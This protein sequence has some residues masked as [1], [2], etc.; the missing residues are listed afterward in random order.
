[1]KKLV[2]IILS[3]L[4][5]FTII[6][7]ASV[8]VSAAGN[9]DWRWPVPSS[10]SLSS[11]Y[12]DGRNHCALD[13]VGA[14]GCAIYA[15]YPGTVVYTVRN[16]CAHNYGTYCGCGGGLGNAVYI[17]H[18]YQ[19][20]SYI[21]RYGHLT[22]VNVSNG[23]SVS[24]NTV[25][26]T[27]G[28]TGDSSGFHLDLRICR[29]STAGEATTAN[30]IDPFK[31]QFLEMPSGFNANGATT[32]CCYTYVNEVKS[33][34]ATPSDTTAPTI[35]NVKVSNVTSTGYT[36]TCNVSDNVG[37]TRVAF[38]TWTAYA[39]QDDLKWKDGTINGN[40]ATFNVKTSDHNNE[41]GIY[42]THIYAYD[43]AGKSTSVATWCNVPVDDIICCDDSKSYKNGYYTDDDEVLRLWGWAFSNKGKEVSFK[44]KIDD[45]NEIKIENVVRTDVKNA[46]SSIC[47]F[48]NVGYDVD[49]EL[50]KVESG[51]HTVVII[52]TST[53]GNS[54]VVSEHSFYVSH[55]A[56][57]ENNKRTVTFNNH[58]YEIYDQYLDYHKALEYCESKGGHLATISSAFENE[59]IYQSIKGYKDTYFLG[60][61]DEVTE[62][63]W[64]WCDGTNMTYSNWASTQPDNAGS[65]EHYLEMWS[66]S[67]L[68]NDARLKSADYYAEVS[69]FICE[70]EDYEEQGY[71]F[72]GNNKYVL[73]NS[74]LTWEEAKTFAEE[75]GGHLVTITSPHENGIVGCLIQVHGTCNNY[76]LGAKKVTETEFE[77]V[78]GEEWIY[79]NWGENEPNEPITSSY[80]QISAFDYEHATGFKEAYT[81]NDILPE[82]GSSDF[83]LL[84]NSGFIVE[85]ENVKK[86]LENCDISLEYATTDYTGKE[87]TPTITIKDGSTT[88]VKGTDYTVEYLNNTDVGTASVVVIGKGNYTGK[89]IK[90]F[91]IV[92]KNH[93]YSDWT[94]IEQA[95]CTEKGEKICACLICEEE[96]KEIIP[97]L[98]HTEVID[99]AVAPTCTK[100]GLTQGKHCSTCD[101]VLVKQE[102]VNKA[103]HTPS[104]DWVVTKPATTENSG[105]RVKHCTVCDEI[106][107]TEVIPKLDVVLPTNISDCEI[108]VKYSSTVY[109][110]SAKKPSV[111]VKD[112]STTL[113]NGTDYAVKYSNNL[114]AG[115]ATITIKGKGNYTGTVTK[116]FE[117]EK[118]SFDSWGLPPETKAV[119]YPANNLETRYT[120][121]MGDY[122]LIKDIDYTVSIVGEI[123]IGNIVKVIYT[124]KG[125]FTGERVYTFK[126]IC[127]QYIDGHI[128]DKWIVETEPTCESEGSEY[129]ICTLCGEKEV[130]TI[131]KLE[132][133]WE[134]VSDYAPSDYFNK[135]YE[136]Y[137][138]VCSECG[139]E[140]EDS[141]I[142]HSI[143]K[144]KLKKPKVSYFSKN[145]I[146]SVKTTHKYAYGYQ[147]R[148]K[149]KGNWKY[150]T[151]TSRK[152]TEI[153]NL[154]K[155]KKGAK[156]KI[157]VR[158]FMKQ[159]SKKAYSDWTG[160][161]TVKVK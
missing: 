99:K 34:Y 62:G 23:Q 64:K 68:W 18:T 139:F 84:K 82:G 55:I 60:A 87:K 157:Q 42:Y 88:L 141:Y 77:W 90:E 127:N 4:L 97:A 131:P 74:F 59:G 98:G 3:V 138:L 101:K 12:L 121:S 134:W 58:T 71:V 61:T 39:D 22:G 136:C 40:T 152:T 78:T 9:R 76:W 151:V 149:I 27:M 45:G 15:C 26:G 111:T 66:E 73:Y 94:I 69:G 1:M 75:K 41:T 158:G 126:I 44:Y 145:R 48:T 32:S 144:L 38:P 140:D 93:K 63:D 115:T 53:S 91:E 36:V 86:D 5:I 103:S 135:G 100:T 43:A 7:I 123:K 14:Q 118:K 96:N 143:P 102:I 17:K 72:S 24:K 13:I 31:S 80:A 148:Y 19:G 65:G 11:C 153:W 105:E 92:C 128:C 28:S 114:N 50:S 147:I 150:K 146:I 35:S 132:H 124:G 106:I 133:S 161:K 79:D 52:A 83:Y 137:W 95:T 67:G 56:D 8:S 30:A 130:S 46:Y 10:N 21:S 108:T 25:I 155:F 107:E 54:V 110:G 2:S 6:P 125:N 70:Y 120:M 85:Y 47:A 20:V 89:I 142:E 116:T 33:L 112:G 160:I 156:Y 119:Q 51:K 81:W 113:I 49:L 109:S 16:V 117:I 159:G 122:K 37:V 104:S 57:L 29:G 129:G 154:G